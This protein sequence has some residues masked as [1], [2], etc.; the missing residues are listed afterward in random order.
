MYVPAFT[1]AL[2][3]DA[4]PVTPLIGVGPAALNV[5][6]VGTAVPPSSLLTT[7]TKVSCAAASLLLI[8]QVADC[9]EREGDGCAGLR[10]ARRTTMPTRH[11][12]W[13][14]TPTARS[15]PHSP[16][17]FVTVALPVAP[18]IGVGPAAL[19]VQSVGTAVPPLS[20]VTVFTNVSWAGMS[21]LLIVHVADCP[22]ASAI[23]APVC[24]PPVHAHADAA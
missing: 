17:A 7:F 4:P 22:S 21:L 10:P 1:G 5:Q 16:A 18:E 8:V 15:C 9:T 14:R 24:V 19:N 12:H 20:L 3:T 6:S 13:D 11:N 2:V 23:D